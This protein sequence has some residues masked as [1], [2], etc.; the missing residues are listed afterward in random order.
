MSTTELSKRV[1]GNDELIKIKNKQIFTVIA[2]CIIISLCFIL[3]KKFIYGKATIRGTSLRPG[4][5]IVFDD[6]SC[7]SVCVIAN[8]DDYPEYMQNGLE[9]NAI[10]IFHSSG[11][12]RSCYGHCINIIYLLHVVEPNEFPPISLVLLKLAGIFLVCLIGV[13]GITFLLYKILMFKDKRIYL[14]SSNKNR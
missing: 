10:G 2:F 9:V 3:S 5:L 13:F 14:K 1:R 8:P 7:S 11:I 6:S 4:Y 12:G